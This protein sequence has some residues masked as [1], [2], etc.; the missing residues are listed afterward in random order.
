MQLAQEE[1]MF[2]RVIIPHAQHE[3][4]VW[5]GIESMCHSEQA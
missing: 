1:A 5:W 2:A 4:H 3:P